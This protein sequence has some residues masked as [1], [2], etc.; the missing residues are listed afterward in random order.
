MQQ[1][2]TIYSPKDEALCTIDKITDGCVE[3][4]KLME[5]DC[6]ELHF[7]IPEPIIFDVGCWC[8]WNGRIF[9]VTDVSYAVE[10]YTSGCCSYEL[11]MDAYYMAW[12]NK[13]FKYVPA[14]GG[15]MEASFT[16]TAKV[17]VHMLALIRCIE[18]HG[19]KYNGVSF[20]YSIE[21]AKDEAKTITY[22]ASSIIDALSSI[23]NA[24]ECEW[25]VTENIIHIGKCNRGEIV[26]L[27]PG[28]NLESIDGTPSK[29]DY[30]TRVYA[31]GSTNNLPANW[32]KEF[33]PIT[34]TSSEKNKFEVDR[35]LRTGYF[36]TSEVSVEKTGISSFYMNARLCLV[37]LIQNKGQ[38]RDRWYITDHTLPFE[39]AYDNIIPGFYDNGCTDGEVNTLRGYYGR[40]VSDYPADGKLFGYSLA[41]VS[42]YGPYNGYITGPTNAN[43]YFKSVRNDGTL[44]DEEELSIKFKCEISEALISKIIQYG[45]TVSFGA[46]IVAYN[47][48]PSS[49][50]YGYI[51]YSMFSGWREVP[52]GNRYISLDVDRLNFYVEDGCDGVSLNTECFL[53]IDDV[54]NGSLTAD[55]IRGNVLFSVGKYGCG[56]RLFTRTED[57]KQTVDIVADMGD[58]SSITGE[59]HFS[60]IVTDTHDGEHT[61]LLTGDSIPSVGDTFTIKNAMIG[62]LPSYWFTGNTSGVYNN[63]VGETRLSLPAPI[64][65][66]EGLDDTQAVERV[67][68]FE[69]IYPRTE[70]VIQDV[71]RE[72]KQDETTGEVY[73]VF[74]I[75]TDEY[76]FST[77]YLLPGIDLKVKFTTG[78]LAGMTFNAVYGN[79]SGNKTV[80][81]AGDYFRIVRTEA[82]GLYLPDDYLNPSAGDKFVL[83]GFDSTALLGMG[84]VEK[85]QKELE[86]AA[87]EKMQ[88]MS[89]D[90][91]TYTAI[92]MCDSAYNGLSMEL[93]RRVRL[94]SK[95]HFYGGVR[96]SR[97]IGYERRMDI[98][99]DRPQYSIGDKPSYSKIGELSEKIDNVSVRTWQ[100][101]ASKSMAGLTGEND[102]LVIPYI[103]K[104]ID[105]TKETDDNIYS[106]LRV[107]SSF[108]SKT[109]DDHSSGMPTMDCGMVACTAL[110]R[111]QMQETASDGIIET[112]TYIDKNGT[113]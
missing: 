48:M 97:V 56:V 67:L 34:V 49:S 36:P 22:Q 21:Y 31:F 44:D 95:A 79:V 71:Q 5:E 53:L 113:N 25:W 112:P 74:H 110:T 17:D 16:I 35:V 10:N 51:A 93:G 76:K 38:N 64:D 80:N 107:K 6:I 37:S 23:S 15:H 24:F 78:S 58:G 81:N 89:E 30:A 66:K 60:F 14:F 11:Q 91:T 40:S 73:R 90:P 83:I 57:V 46:E 32:N 20:Q 77:S 69:D 106:A 63:T 82:G 13:I 45:C 2:I 72:T 28:V 39:L 105:N 26:D 1:S 50:K 3:R 100:Q 94:H 18:H 85:A 33:A 7:S 59:K 19:F 8:E 9:Y 111:E 65:Y 52:H 96:V 61:E 92:I 109:E 12:K 62:A 4:V 43:I 101:Q 98:P 54:Y 70:A 84:L 108:L 86:E 88:E 27:E 41:E 55:D 87:R 68:T 104:R 75:R 42:T 47:K 103:I 99:W 102:G 29:S